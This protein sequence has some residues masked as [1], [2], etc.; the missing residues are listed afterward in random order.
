[1]SGECDSGYACAYQFNVS[2]RSATTPVAAE[3]NPR[4]VFE[5]L[6]GAGTAQERKRN[7]AIRQQTNRSI[8]DF[9][10]EDARSLDGKLS[11]QDGRKLDEYLTS[12]R[13]AEERIIKFEQV[14][15]LPNEDMLAPDGRPDAFSE[16]MQVMFDMIVLAFQTDSTR[17]VTLMLAHDGSNRRYPE[18]GVKRGHHDLSHHQGREENLEM[19][20]EIDKYHMRHFGQFLD[21]LAAAKDADGSSILHNSMIVYASGNADGNAHSHTNLPVILAGAGGGK[22]QTGRF[23][24]VGSMPMSNMYLEMLEHMGIEGVNRFGDSNNR[25]AAI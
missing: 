23:H 10:R 7:L 21:K 13:D 3:T 9:V 17:I 5:R 8:L 11:R 14:A 6:F 19:I 15:K 4:H 1:M 12:L 24:Q 25:R 18:I 22:L 20:G 16:R 2:W